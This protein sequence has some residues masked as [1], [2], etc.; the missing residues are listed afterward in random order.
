MAAQVCKRPPAWSIQET[1]DLI[2]VWGEESVQAE[3]RTSRKNADI[4]AKIA[5][6]M[7]E[8]GYTRDTQQCR[9]KI[10]ELRQAYQKTREVNSRSGA[11]PQTCHFYEQLHAILAGD[12]NT[13]HGYHPGTQAAT[14]NNEEDIVDEEEEEEEN[15]QQVSRGSILPGSQELFLTLEPVPS[16]DPLVRDCDGGEGTSAQRLSQIRRRKKQTREDM[17]C[18]LM[19]SSKGD[20]AQLHAWR[21]TLSES[22]RIDQEG[23]KASKEQECNTQEEMLQ[24]MGAQTDMLRHLVEVQERQLDLRVQLHPVMNEL[25]SSPSSISSSPR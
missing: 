9:V 25:P 15:V 7:G 23:R 22:M 24:L 12:P 6:G 21:L 5:Q 3:L 18:D 8:K 16:Q 2:A 14:G 4:S 20:R 17:F 10:K 11:E 1:L 19:C 13:V